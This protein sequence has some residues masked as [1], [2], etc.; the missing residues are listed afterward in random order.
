MGIPFE[1]LE[2]AHQIRRTL[3]GEKTEAEATT[4]AWNAG[5]QRRACEVCSAAIT[6]DLEVHHIQPRASAIEGRLADGSNMNALRNL[7]VV[8]EACHDKHHANELE[9]GQVKQTSVGP[10]RDYEY[11]PSASARVSSGLTDEQ[12][13]TIKAELKA[14]PNLPA[15]RMV[16]DLEDRHGIKITSQRL[17]AIR[18]TVV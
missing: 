15:S 3:A 4:S 13:E 11:R 6:R 10:L 16:F 8:C 5:V 7:V 9:I 14:F 1:V 2:S 12:M 17:R 18:T